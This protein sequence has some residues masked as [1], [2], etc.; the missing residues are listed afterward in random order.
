MQS[1]TIKHN[2]VKTSKVLNTLSEVKTKTLFQKNVNNFVT[3]IDDD[4]CYYSYNPN[5]REIAFMKNKK[6]VSY[7]IWEVKE[8]FDD[9]KKCSNRFWLSLVYN[10]AR[11]NS[12][13]KY[14]WISFLEYSK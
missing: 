11:V 13:K 5:I 2:V 1:I 7:Y 10:S 9:L 14:V 3:D 6:V 8:L 12:L 4:W